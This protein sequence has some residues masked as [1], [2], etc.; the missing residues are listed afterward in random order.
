MYKVIKNVYGLFVMKEEFKFNLKK[1]KYTCRFCNS[2]D[3]ITEKNVNLTI[4]FLKSLEI[5]TILKQLTE[6]LT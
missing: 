6:F 3:K 2:E 4:H 5:L 1:I